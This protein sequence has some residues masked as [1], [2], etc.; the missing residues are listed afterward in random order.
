MI[1]Y[2]LDINKNK[3]VFLGRVIL[4]EKYFVDME[5]EKL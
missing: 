5:Q 3:E 4:M 2:C 1:K